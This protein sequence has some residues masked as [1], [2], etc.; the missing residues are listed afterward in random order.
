MMRYLIGGVAVMTALKAIGWAINIPR[1]LG[2][3]LY[4]EQFLGVMLGL[5]LLL[6]FL[7][8]NNKGGARKG[9]TPFYDWLAGGVAFSASLYLAHDY[10]GLMFAVFDMSLSALIVALLIPH[11]VFM[12]GVLLNLV[13]G[14]ALLIFWVV[15]LTKK[16]TIKSE[17]C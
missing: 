13:G 14:A 6:T 16:R 12:G 2:F 15:S 17:A 3:S 7:G 1:Y 5:T 8:T 10:E 4:T 11:D 9:R